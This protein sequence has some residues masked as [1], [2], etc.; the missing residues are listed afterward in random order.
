MNAE[1]NEYLALYLESFGLGQCKQRFLFPVL[2]VAAMG[3][4]TCRGRGPMTAAMAAW[5]EAG[6]PVLRGFALVLIDG[7]TSSDPR[8]LEKFS[9]VNEVF[10]KFF[11]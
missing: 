4:W 9:Q 3:V 10:G 5:T 2:E 8:F 6:T 11:L 1:H 7:F